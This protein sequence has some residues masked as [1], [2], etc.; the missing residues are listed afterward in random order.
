MQMCCPAGM[1]PQKKNLKILPSQKFL[2]KDG[3]IN[4]RTDIESINF[5][6]SIIIITKNNLSYGA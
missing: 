5:M 1:A 2:V 4:I 3:E 6:N